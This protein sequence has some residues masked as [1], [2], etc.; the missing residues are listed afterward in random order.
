[1]ELWHVISLYVVGLGL[2]IAECF[3]PGGILG[4]VGGAALVTSVIFG[5]SEHWG[6]GTVQIAITV[7]VVPVAFMAGMK[8]V[9]HKAS[10]AGSASF[11][12][13]YSVYNGREGEAKT[14]LRPSGMVDIDGNKV[15]VVT[16]GEMVEQGQRVR[17]VKVEGNR[18]I[19]RAI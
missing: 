2:A 7:V 14:D 9:A 4:M 15:D 17:V 18:V 6:V 3:I 11:A 8:R 13:D 16:A 19:V 1:M 5:F 10:L 12:K